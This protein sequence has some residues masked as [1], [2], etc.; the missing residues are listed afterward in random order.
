MNPPDGLGDDGL[1]QAFAQALQQ[2]PPGDR[3]D[4]A[5]VV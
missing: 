5:P 4:R 1:C 2:R 3:Q